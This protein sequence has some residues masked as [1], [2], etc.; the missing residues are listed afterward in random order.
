MIGF[1]VQINDE[2]PVTAGAEDLS[3]LTAILTMVFARQDLSL[4]VG[5]MISRSATD[6]EMLDWVDR[7]LQAGD[8][9]KLKVIE[10]A[11]GSEALRHTRTDPDLE[12]KAQRKYYERLKE[13]YG[14]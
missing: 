11:S 7:R 10:R 2:A 4:R 6:N 8:T 14:E 13:E 5:G 12:E 1:E 9:V 3:V